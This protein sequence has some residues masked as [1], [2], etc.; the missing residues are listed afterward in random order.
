MAINEEVKEAF[1]VELKGIYEDLNEWINKVHQMTGPER[2][3]IREVISDVRKAA[4][5]LEFE[6]PA[7]FV[8]GDIRA[9][10]EI[11]QDRLK[12]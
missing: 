6:V 11:L 1:A 7:T 10:C 2:L 3:E 8:I 9:A 12:G 5:G 4:S